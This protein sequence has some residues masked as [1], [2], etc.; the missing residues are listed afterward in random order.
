LFISGGRTEEF[1]ERMWG[2]AEGGLRMKD[3]RRFYK[4]YY[5]NSKVDED[6]E[7]SKQKEI[8]DL[9]VNHENGLC[10]LDIEIATL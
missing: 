3:L 1:L 8:E 6:L 5:S 9:L 7:R 10:D 2:L 4:E